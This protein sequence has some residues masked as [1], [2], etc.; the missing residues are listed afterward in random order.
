MYLC[1]F[2]VS[3]VVADVDVVRGADKRQAC[4]GERNT[5]S[6]QKRDRFLPFARHAFVN[7][8]HDRAEIADCEKDEVEENARLDIVQNAA[9]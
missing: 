4:R 1:I 7:H 2:F 3:A 5:S 6:G 9:R 8:H